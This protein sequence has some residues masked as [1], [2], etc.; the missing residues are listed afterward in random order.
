MQAAIRLSASR[1]P[2]LSRSVYRRSPSGSSPCDTHHLTSLLTGLI[3]CYAAGSSSSCA[4]TSVGGGGMP[5]RPRDAM[6]L[7]WTGVGIA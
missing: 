2:D 5:R 3:A 1:P 6:V 4:S 7:R